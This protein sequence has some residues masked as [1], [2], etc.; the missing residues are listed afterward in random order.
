MSG[1]DESADETEHGSKGSERWGCFDCGHIE[2]AAVDKLAGRLIKK[3]VGSGRR[4]EVIET[5]VCPECKSENWHSE[6][7]SEAF[8]EREIDGQTSQ[9]YGGMS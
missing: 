3:T 1:R 7:V 4:E 6:S 5:V 8:F 9:N 2:S